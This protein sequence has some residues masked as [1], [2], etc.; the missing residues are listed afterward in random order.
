MS[1]VELNPDADQHDRAAI[2]AAR[3]LHEGMAAAVVRG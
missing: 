1:V 3:L 2:L